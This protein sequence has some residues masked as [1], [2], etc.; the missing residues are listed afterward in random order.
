MPIRTAGRIAVLNWFLLFLRNTQN[1]SISGT[2]DYFAK[3]E[4]DAYKHVRDLLATTKQ[5][6][7]RLVPADWQE[8]G[9]PLVNATD[10]GL[11]NI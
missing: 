2:T 9:K 8:S 11:F 10:G 5:S 3:E 4:A 6:Q 1:C 7:P